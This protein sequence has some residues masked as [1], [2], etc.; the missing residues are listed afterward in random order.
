[1]ADANCDE[2]GE[3][4]K[5]YQFKLM[6][7][8]VIHNLSVLLIEFHKDGKSTSTQKIYDCFFDELSKSAQTFY[9][10]KT[11]AFD[12]AQIVHDGLHQANCLM[13]QFFPDILEIKSLHDTSEDMY[14]IFWGHYFYLNGIDGAK[15]A[16]DSHPISVWEAAQVFA[17]KFWNSDQD[18]FAEPIG[19]GYQFIL[20]GQAQ[21]MGQNK[22]RFDD[23]PDL[24]ARFDY[25]KQTILGF[26]YFLGCSAQ[27]GKKGEITEDIHARLAR[28]PSVDPNREFE[29]LLGP[30][31]DW[32]LNNTYDELIWRFN[33]SI[34]ARKIQ[35]AEMAFPVFVYNFKNHGIIC[36]DDS[37]VARLHDSEK[38]FTKAMGILGDQLFEKEY[39]ATKS[40][41]TGFCAANLRAQADAMTTARAGAFFDSFLPLIFA[42]ANGITKQKKLSWSGHLKIQIPLQQFLLGLPHDLGET[43]WAYQ[44]SIFFKDGLP[45]AGIEDL[46]IN[47]FMIECKAKVIEFYQKHPAKCQELASANNHWSTFPHLQKDSDERESILTLINQSLGYDVPSQ[48]Y[49]EE[50]T[51]KGLIIFGYFCSLCETILFQEGEKKLQ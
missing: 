36:D 40:F 24:L 22:V 2:N 13:Y 42:A 47:P 26:C 29:E 25:S 41:K 50:C 16:E 9:E 46:E 5:E 21:A 12:E 20:E 34:E 45:R 39:D 28:L 43:I 11:G 7:H 48:S 27:A 32:I 8:S 10:L 30:L 15:Q 3:F 38:F 18:K 44:S 4:T 31:N 37:K 1:M 17:N 19:L 23:I 33:G 6:T 49:A 51:L 35:T 14:K